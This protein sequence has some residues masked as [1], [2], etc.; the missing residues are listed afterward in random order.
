MADYS[1]QHPSNRYLELLEQYRKMHEQGEKLLGIPP[2]STFTGLSLL[3]QVVRIKNLIDLTTAE[4]LLDYGSGKGVQYER[5]YIDT[6]EKHFDSVLDYWDIEEMTC[7]DPGFSPFSGLPTQNFDG[8]IST[9]V[10]EHC[11]VDDLPWIID[12]IFCYAEK[13]VF[14]N[15]ASYP[16][17]K[18]LPN[19]E[20]A[21]CTQQGK[22]WWEDLINKV[23]NAYSEISW[24]FWLQIK[25][26]NNTLEEHRFA[27]FS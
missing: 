5:H 7:Y 15:I 4:T 9:D 21:H 10:L 27:N 13:F 24:E 1:R 11:P 16:A 3:P 19:G 6:E 8:V 25:G 23:A 22:E 2:E 20:N 12:E 14:A 18:S 17:K 26:Q